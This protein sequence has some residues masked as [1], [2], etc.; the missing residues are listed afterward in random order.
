VATA[1][2]PIWIV[3]GPSCD[4]PFGHSRVSEL[5]LVLIFLTSGNSGSANGAKMLHT[6]RQV[7][8]EHHRTINMGIDFIL[9][10]AALI[11][12]NQGE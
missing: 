2:L 10:G 5:R 9:V 6:L 11:V 8:L 4:A 3:M 1:S 12:G 7:V